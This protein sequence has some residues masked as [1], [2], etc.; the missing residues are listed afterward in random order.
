MLLINVLYTFVPYTNVF[1]VHDIGSL[2]G[3]ILLYLYLL[4]KMRF[5]FKNLSK[6]WLILSFT[7]HFVSLLV[8]RIEH[9]V[10]TCRFCILGARD[11]SRARVHALTL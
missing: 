10:K 6:S 3:T 2:T 11:V 9:F 8:V 5:S 7:P 4:D 1:T